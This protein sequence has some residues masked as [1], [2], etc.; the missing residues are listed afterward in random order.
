MKRIL[1]LLLVLALCLA[2]VPLREARAAD[3]IEVS[4]IV[5]TSNISSFLVS[6]GTI[7]EPTFTLSQGSPAYFNTHMGHWNKKV[8]GVWTRYD[9]GDFTA[10]TWAYETQIRIDGDSGLTHV[11]GQDCTVRVDGKNWTLSSYHGVGEDFSYINAASPEFTVEDNGVLTFTKPG[12]LKIETSYVNEAISSF[13]VSGY[14]SGGT[15]PYTFSKTSGPDWISVSSA[16]LVSGTPTQVNL[17]N[18]SLVVRV[19]DKKSNYKEISIYVDS[20]GLKDEDKTQVSSIVATSNIG[21]LLVNG[22]TIQE[23]TFTM[24]QGS[25]AY[26]NTH[27]GHWNKK[28]DGVWTRYDSGEFTPGTWAYETQI[29]IDGESGITHA[30]ARDCAVKVDG[31]TWTLSSYYG[32]GVTFS[33]INVASPEFTIT[34]NPSIASVAVTFTAPAIGARPDYDPEFPSGAHYY[35]YPSSGTYIK[36]D[37]RWIDVTDNEILEVS[38]ATFV[39]GHVYRVAIGLMPREGYAFAPSVTAKINGKTAG[40]SFEGSNIALT[41]T[42]P[43]VGVKPTITT[44]PANVTVNEGA[45]TTFTVT[46]TDAES[47][48]WQ[49]SSD[50]GKTWNNSTSATTGYNTNTLQVNAAAKRNGYK[51]RC[52]VTNSTGTVTSSAATLTVKSK[53]VITTQPES[54]AVYVGNTAAFKVVATSGELSYRWQYQK[55]GESTWNNVTVN[56]TSATYTLTTAARHN[57]YKYKCVVSNSAGS[58]TSSVVTLTVS[59]KPLITTQPKS[60]TVTAGNTATFKVVAVGADSY[61]WQYQ[62]PGESTWN[63]V[64]TNGT[65]A[66]YTL[67]TA[68][69]HNGY[70]YRCKV[71]NAKGTTTSSVVT[72][73]V[74]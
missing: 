37:V 11:L 61:Q 23:P 38:S 32:S 12:S 51:Y 59:V 58:V 73:T 68:A 44:Q 30:L 63:N 55:P 15:K 56:G 8:D 26:F 65:S 66:T 57:G 46:A 47:Y 60:V 41:Y 39:T 22:G 40:V 72:L 14:A 25:P 7:Q 10:G 9:S 67:T 42:F 4:T 5:A 33:Y 24:S 19:T 20:T 45:K 43:A 36:N 48:Q 71:T 27:M 69:R 13:S 54:T 52:K 62:K 35:S 17:N 53:P 6:G 64:K 49:W 34:N 50:K 70:K 16:G 29:R 1:S 18:D 74:N 2:L 21:S 31:R 3:R 28:V